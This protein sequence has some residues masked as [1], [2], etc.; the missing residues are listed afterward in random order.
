[1]KHPPE[2]STID[3]IQVGKE[4]RQEERPPGGSGIQSVWACEYVREEERQYRKDKKQDVKKPD[5]TTWNTRGGYGLKACKLL[6]NY[7]CAPDNTC[8]HYPRMYIFY[9]CICY[10]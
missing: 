5:W 6:G 2:T 1:M 10:I 8:S 9:T 4:N 3:F 7:L